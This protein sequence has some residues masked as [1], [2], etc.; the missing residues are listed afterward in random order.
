MYPWKET[1]IY[2]IQEPYLV[3]FSD[4]R[5][6]PQMKVLLNDPWDNREASKPCSIRNTEPDPN[7]FRMSRGFPAFSSHWESSLQTARC[8]PG[9]QT[10]TKSRQ[11]KFN[12]FLLIFVEKYD[13]NNVPQNMKPKYFLFFLSKNPTNSIPGNKIKLLSQEYLQAFQYLYAL[14]R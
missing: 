11:Y 9:A 14:Q 4:S 2:S 5:P 6:K 3:K 7:T 10:Q 8:T 1:K 12:K 13:L